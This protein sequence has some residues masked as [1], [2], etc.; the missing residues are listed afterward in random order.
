MSLPVK[1][2]EGKLRNSMTEIHNTR[3]FPSKECG[4]ESNKGEIND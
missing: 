4:Y 2:L 3:K 1:N